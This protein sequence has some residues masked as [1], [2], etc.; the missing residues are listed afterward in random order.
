MEVAGLVIADVRGV[1][2]YRYSVYR[3]VVD[4]YSDN[5]TGAKDTEDAFDMRKPLDRDKDL[6]WIRENGEEHRVGPEDVF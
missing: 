3:R 1:L 4:Y 6:K 5:M 2:N